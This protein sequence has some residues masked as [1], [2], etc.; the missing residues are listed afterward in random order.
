MGQLHPPSIIICDLSPREDY[1]PPFERH[2]I[3]NKN[4]RNT[5]LAIAVDSYLSFE[6]KPQKR[7]LGQPRL[8]VYSLF[9]LLYGIPVVITAALTKF[10]TGQ[11]IRIHQVGIA[12]WFISQGVGTSVMQV[13]TLWARVNI[14][15]QAP[16]RQHIV[17]TATLIIVV[18]GSGVILY[19]IVIWQ[20][21]LF[22]H[23]PRK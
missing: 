3:Y 2:T 22:V 20:I 15:W 19:V 16:W 21:V 23:L 7:W 6:R 8:F 10:N 5:E 13:F 12:V 18:G 14:M 11:S 4:Q 9:L 17:L 1:S